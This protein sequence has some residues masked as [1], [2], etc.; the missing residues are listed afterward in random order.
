MH[1]LRVVA[2]LFA[3]QV[4][5]QETGYVVAA[6][7]GNVWET[8]IAVSPANPDHAV[9]IGVVAQRGLATVQP[10]YTEDGGRSWHYGGKLGLETAKHKYVRH[11]DPVVASGRDGVMYAAT[12]IGDPVS[13]PL[14]YSGIAAYRSKD[15]GKTWEGPFGVV[16]RAPEQKPFYADDKEW[17]SVDATGGKYDGN[18]YIAWIDS[19]GGPQLTRSF[20]GTIY[21]SRSTDGGRTWSA[22]RAITQIANTALFQTIACDPVTGE[23]LISWLDRRANATGK[24]FRLYMSR[25]SD[26][27]ATFQEHQPVTSA[28]DMTVL[29]TNGS[30]FI[31]DY[32]QMVGYNRVFLSAFSDGTG[33]MSVA[34]IEVPAP[35]PKRRAVRK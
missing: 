17:I 5:G 34:R 10:F 24:Q 9:A 1:K 3:L 11:G 27:G 18:L 32:N 12:L 22:P 33:K 4:S 20:V 2:L 35:G 21:F 31:G 25:S 30:G 13:Y 28:V 14:K 6:T 23:L 16:E 7:E 8:S 29:P 26:G 15:N 19:I